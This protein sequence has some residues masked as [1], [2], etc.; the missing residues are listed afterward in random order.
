MG[1]WN[2]ADKY[3]GEAKEVKRQAD[4]LIY[5]SYNSPLKWPHCAVWVRP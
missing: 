5:G 2:A 1:G 3:A 4:G